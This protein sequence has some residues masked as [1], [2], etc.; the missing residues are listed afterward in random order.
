[1]VKQKSNVNET[2]KSSASK[3]QKRHSTPSDDKLQLLTTTSNITLKTD[4]ILKR[5]EPH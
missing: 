2:S 3:R 5:Q 1:M 4:V